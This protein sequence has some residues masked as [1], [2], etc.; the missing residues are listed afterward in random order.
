MSTFVMLTRLGPEAARRPHMLEALERDVARVVRD[1][2]PDVTWV[3]NLAL[4]GPYDYLDV[5]RAPSLDE[6]MK[7]AAVV[8][9][10]GHAQTEVWSAVQWDRFRDLMAQLPEEIGMS[11]VSH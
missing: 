5:F 9:L 2:C 3:M 7:V 10:A 1:T 11:V 4:L 6:A 8:R